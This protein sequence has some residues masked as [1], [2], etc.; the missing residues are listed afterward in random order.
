MR[1]VDTIT[2]RRKW[3]N[4]DDLKIVPEN[5]NDEQK[6]KVLRVAFNKYTLEE[7]QK[8]LNVKNNEY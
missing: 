3:E 4:K 2:E 5:I 7:L 1:R 6:I 8:M